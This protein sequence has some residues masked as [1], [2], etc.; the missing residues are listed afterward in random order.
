MLLFPYQLHSSYLTDFSISSFPIKTLVSKSVKRHLDNF[1]SPT[2]FKVASAHY[3]SV[4]PLVDSLFRL[5]HSGLE[6]AK[7]LANELMIYAQSI[8]LA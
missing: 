1:F 5:D 4:P 8:G 2:P 7:F 3:W 6:P